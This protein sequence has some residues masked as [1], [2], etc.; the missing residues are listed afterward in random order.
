MPQITLLTG[1]ERRRRWSWDERRRILN[2]AF[3]PGAVVADVSRQFE[4]STSL[5]YKW[6]R[7]AM[8]ETSM[9]FAPAVLLPEAA[10]IASPADTTAITV[11]L[12]N[13]TRLRIDAQASPALVTAALQA[14]R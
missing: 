9:P 14:L 13:G 10:P 7:Q 2:A 6:R 11:E 4:V 3:M 8:T 5:I 1:P 12:V